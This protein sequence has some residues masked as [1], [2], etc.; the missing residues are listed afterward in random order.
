[1]GHFADIG[2]NTKKKTDFSVNFKK[3]ITA[4]QVQL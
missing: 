4:A 1:M 2:K 3:N